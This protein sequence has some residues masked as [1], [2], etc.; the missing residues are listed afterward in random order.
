MTSFAQSVRYEV[1]GSVATIT[2]DRSGARNAFDQAMAESLLASLKTARKDDQVRIV[3]LTGRGAAFSAGQDIHELQQ[4][5]TELGAQAAGDELRKRFR[6]ILLEI[7]SMDKPVVAAVNGVATG[8]GL[9]IA[10]ASDLR[11]A[12]ESASFIC[13]PHAIALIPGAGITWLLP[14]LAGFGAASELALLGERIDAKRALE[15]GLLNWVAPDDELVARTRDLCGALLQQ[16]AS[17]LSL[18]KRALN[19][20][21]FAGF[22]QHLDYEADLQEVAA[23]SDEHIHRLRGMVERGSNRR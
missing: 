8:A 7:R 17:S 13:A 20:S 1:E 14:R 11:I 22:E 23:A 6:P 18:T 19:R 4:K 12:A 21:L 15:L 2:L 5:E 16:P 10:L 9:G 3:V